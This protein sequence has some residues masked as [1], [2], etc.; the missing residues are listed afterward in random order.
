MNAERQVVVLD[1][2]MLMMPVEL[3]VRTFDHIERLLGAVE[4]VITESVQAELE[5][6]SQGSGK[7]ATAA[8]VG[9]ELA[10]KHCR[11]VADTADSTDA[12]II[13][14]ATA[15]A[16]D[17]VATNDAEVRTAVLDAGI[18]VISLRG[19]TQLDIIQP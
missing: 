15:R 4:L 10:D 9:T 5:T 11:V 2:N 1:T 18:P 13:G 19:R 8:S 12:S 3:D 7:E 14:L 17:Y 6:L 16:V